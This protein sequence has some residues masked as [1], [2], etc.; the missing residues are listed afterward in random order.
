VY[1][2]RSLS[3]T[4]TKIGGCEPAHVARQATHVHI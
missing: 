4:E 1:R 3:R 2:G